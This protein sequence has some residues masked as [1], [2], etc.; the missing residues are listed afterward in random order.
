MAMEPFTTRVVSTGSK[1][2]RRVLAAHAPQMGMTAAAILATK[3]IHTFS[4]R[5]LA[6]V[7]ICAGIRDTCNIGDAG[8]LR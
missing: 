5:Y 6:M 1:G 8:H 7:G 3:M 2:E 4:P